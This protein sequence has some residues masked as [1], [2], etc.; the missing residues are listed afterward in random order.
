MSVLGVLDSRG[1]RE[2]WTWRLGRLDSQRHWW[3]DF[4]RFRRIRRLW[5]LQR[6]W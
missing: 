2:L 3:L 1:K 4:R 5:W 6:L